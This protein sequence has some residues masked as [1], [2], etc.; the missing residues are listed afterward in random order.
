MDMIS[1]GAQHLLL[2]GSTLYYGP[3][4][5]GAMALSL[6]PVDGK[7]G[8][9]A[10][11]FP[12]LFGQDAA[13]LNAAPYQVSYAVNP[14]LEMS[15]YYTLSATDRVGNEA[16]SPQFALVKDS[17]AP[18]AE[19]FVPAQPALAFRVNWQGQDSQA[20][21]DYYDLQYRE[22][23][24]QDWGDWLD[25]Q[26]GTQETSARFVGQAGY[27]YQ[28]RVRAAD[29]VGN[30]GEWVTGS[31]AAV[32]N[33]TIYYYAG[34]VRV[35]MRQGERVTYLLADQLGSTQVTADEQG[36]ELGR[37]LYTAWGETR[38]VSGETATD[39]LYTGQ[40]QETEIGLYY[41]NARWYDPALGR[42]VQADTIVPE[43]QGVQG[44]DRFA[45][46]YN[47]PV[48]Y[49]DPSGN[50]AFEDSPDDPYWSKEKITYVIPKP[51][52]QCTGDCYD[53]Y[54]TYLSVALIMG[55]IPKLEDLLYMTA[56]TEYAIL[57]D[58]PKV[59]KY[60]QEALARNYYEACYSATN[61]G[62]RG[63][64]LYKF[65]SGYEPWTDR[66]G[67]NNNVKSPFE[68]ASYLI[69]ALDSNKSW[70]IA[71]M[72]WVLNPDNRDLKQW[73][74]GKLEDRPWQWFGP[75]SPSI[76]C[77]QQVSPLYS[78]SLQNNTFVWILTPEQDTAFHTFCP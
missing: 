60:G 37:Y 58:D 47:N 50:W 72:K 70:L 67:T 68:R 10:V 16:L 75:F 53:A 1:Q 12:A 48:R 42:F 36:S 30:L 76:G 63:T 15:G 19:V 25:W 26:T 46:V 41:Y 9:A 69:K 40:R 5:S 52:K 45:Y 29:R 34:S 27:E 24:A 61:N 38:Q 23:E 49:T 56:E 66:S 71:D 11:G 13:L 31:P 3:L 78:V 6:A 74:L 33:V 32:Q 62:C 28:F 14:G 51:G 59:R 44:W 43:S 73:Q 2:E 65:L 35:A 77:A 55:G 7:S 20:G 64:Q 17:T 8:V 39:R 54:Q 57:A 22:K 21:V 18:T 4:S